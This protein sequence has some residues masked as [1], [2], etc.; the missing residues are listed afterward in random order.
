M[1]LD[2]LNGNSEYNMLQQSP[3]SMTNRL[4]SASPLSPGHELVCESLGIG[5]TLHVI[6]TK[7]LDTN[8]SQDP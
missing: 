7:R 1:S 4:S 5:L 6:L 2:R 3:L 8:L